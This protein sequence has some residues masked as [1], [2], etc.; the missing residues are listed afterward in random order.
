MNQ[1][2]RY[3][4]KRNRSGFTL[5]ELMIS[6]ALSLLLVA[7]INAIFRTTADTVGTGTAAINTARDLRNAF[8][9]IDGDFNGMLDSA[10]QPYLLIYNTNVTGFRDKL[11]EKTDAAYGGA[12]NENNALNEVVAGAPLPLPTP[13]YQGSQM[14]LRTNNRNHR[15]DILSFFA[16]G[17]FRR[18]TGLSQGSP[19]TLQGM[20]TSDIAC[21]RYGHVDLPPLTSNVAN[22]WTTPSRYIPPGMTQI[23]GT[24]QTAANNPN[25]FYGNQFVLGRNAILTAQPQA[26]GASNKFVVAGGQRQAYLNPAI[27]ASPS[28]AQLMVPFAANTTA[29]YT[30]NGAPLKDSQGA[31]YV[32]QDSRIDVAGISATDY[33]NRVKLAAVTGGPSTPVRFDAWYAPLLST[34][35]FS[36]ALAPQD[37][38]HFAC[39]PWLTRT[40]NVVDDMAVTTPAFIK[41][42]SQF[43]VEFAGDYA[44]QDMTVAN[45][46][47]ITGQASD[48]ILDFDAVAVGPRYQ[49]RV[50]WYGLPRNYPDNNS[51]AVR[52]I[53]V[54]PIREF[55]RDTTRSNIPQAKVQRLPFE[56][57]GYTAAAAADA[58]PRQR[59]QQVR[60]YVC[61][62]SPFDLQ[63]PL[64]NEDSPA[65]LDL[66]VV[67]TAG[68]LPMAK[69]Y[70][71]GFMPWM[72]RLTIRVDDPNGRLADGQTIEYIFNLPHK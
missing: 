33:L 9:A 32:I 57:I 63:F 16:S 49:N 62:F 5:V 1:R 43:I 37:T 58:F 54:L 48:G 14:S 35:P 11:D 67:T 7:G 38:F 21:V 17:K 59:P 41:G 25:G 53:D 27:P 72:I 4:P 71:K 10:N 65:T 34:K 42:C 68:P 55:F 66:S 8:D 2:L 28:S 13:R 3:I 26:A 40:A 52:N 56:R 12:Q 69:A 29:T 70:P 36:T 47:K 50:R 19:G 6:I 22:A 51:A 44:T 39:K 45:Y 60:S 61:A 15:L 23:G 31:N 20:Y 30:G 46:G 64:V 24:A 18:Q